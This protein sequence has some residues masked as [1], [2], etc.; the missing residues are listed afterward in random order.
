[1]SHE[2]GNLKTGHICLNAISNWLSQYITCNIF[3]EN[4]NYDP[5][6]CCV[7]QN[8]LTKDDLN[9]HILPETVDVATM[10]FV[11]S[12]IHPDRMVDALRNV[13]I[14]SIKYK[15]P[16]KAISKHQN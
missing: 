15:G 14:V 2:L 12:A 6:R 7:F 11:L 1:M 5:S 8:D 9:E 4:P 3:Q 13:H 16:H 10:I